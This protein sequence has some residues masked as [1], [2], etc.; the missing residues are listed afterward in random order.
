MEQSGTMS[1]GEGRER[2]LNEAYLL[3]I[4]YGYA[5]V[6]MQQIADAAGLTKATMYHHFRGKDELFAAVGQCEMGRMHAGVSELIAEGGTL[7]VVL[8]RVARFF[9]VTAGDADYVRLFSDLRR[10]LSPEQHKT[11]SGAVR[12]PAQLI[13]PL[14]EHGVTGGELRAIDPDLAVEMFF[15]LIMGQIKFAM[16]G[17]SERPPDPERAALLVDALLHGIGAAT[18]AGV[19]A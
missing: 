9:L 6:S 7:P 10:H 16:D 19:R 4:R 15:G 12:H 11:L 2:I 14:F 18:P 3:F 8:E 17:Q 13:R 5:E 1:S